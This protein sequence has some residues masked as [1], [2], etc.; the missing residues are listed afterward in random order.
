MLAHEADVEE[1]GTDAD[2]KTMIKIP[3]KAQTCKML[4]MTSYENYA[5][6]V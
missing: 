3:S 2:G 5:E 6:T 4:V 1:V